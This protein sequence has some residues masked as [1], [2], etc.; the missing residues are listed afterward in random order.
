MGFRL[1]KIGR[2]PLGNDDQPND[3]QVDHPTVS[4]SHLSVFISDENEVFITDLDSANGTYVNGNRISGDYQLKQGDI[5]KLGM[6][7][8]IRWSKWLDESLEGLKEP[9]NGQKPAEEKS[10]FTKTAVPESKKKS[11]AVVQNALIGLLL[12]LIAAGIT[13]YILLGKEPSKSASPQKHIVYTYEELKQMDFARLQ[14]LA[15]KKDSVMNVSSGEIKLKDGKT[16]ILTVDKERLVKVEE[17]TIV[18]QQPPKEEP[19]PTL[20]KDK[21]RDGIPDEKDKCPE[22][23][24]NKCGT[25]QTEEVNDVPVVPRD[26]RSLG[27]GF[28]STQV[29]SGGE[30]VPAFHRR[31]SGR[32]DIL[33]LGTRRT[34]STQ[35]QIIDINHFQYVEGY[36]IERGTWVKF[37]VY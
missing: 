34:I 16:Y 2:T 14:Q 20:I 33:S 19:K 32:N 28:Y 8:P 21:D 18:L 7:P 6:A 24:T 29:M 11:K 35:D 30:S 1:L 10:D 5:L 25:K 4:R 23:P 22:D 15:N 31:I 36:I 12:L 13:A 3:I 26:I 17:V 37:K 9:D 27:N